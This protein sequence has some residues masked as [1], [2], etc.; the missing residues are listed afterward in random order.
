M[1]KSVARSAGFAPVARSDAR[2]LILGSLPGRRS[3]DAGQYY[4]HPQNAFWRIMA[5]LVGASGDY[6]Q[7][8][9]A[10]LDAGIAVWDVLADSLRP[11]SM[12]ANIDLQSATA[13]NFAGFFESHR[14]IASVAFNGKTAERVYRQLVQAHI[15][16]SG[17]RYLS[18]PSSSP[19]YAAMSFDDKLVHW[20]ALI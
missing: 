5:E 16:D 18:L 14:C 12:D 19:A 17:I 9:A 1:Q 10:L 6:E 13:N 11:G 2:I 4:A 8:C 15:E 20:R 3:I 7:R